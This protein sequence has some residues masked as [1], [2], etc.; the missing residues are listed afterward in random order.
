VRK[1]GRGLSAAVINQHL[2]DR[3]KKNTSMGPQRIGCGD[4]SIIHE[5]DDFP[6][7]IEPGKS[8]KTVEKRRGKRQV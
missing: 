2:P 3:S 7:G 4:A 8:R 5:V 6:V 1:K